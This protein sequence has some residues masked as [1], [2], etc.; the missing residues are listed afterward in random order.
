M[1]D[2]K[3]MKKAEIFSLLVRTGR[4][5]VMQKGAEFLTARK[6]S[7]A[8]GCSVGTIYNQFANMDNFIIVQNM[9]TLDELYEAMSQIVPSQNSYKNLV[10]YLDLYVDWVLH[11][12]NLWFLLFNFH[13]YRDGRNFPADY[14]RKFLKISQ[15]WQKDFE[16]S[17]RGLSIKE[18]RVL[19]QV[20]MLSMFSLSSFLSTQKT[21][22]I[23]RRNICKMFLNTYLA[24]VK[25]LCRA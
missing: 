9:L 6:L 18:R 20:L 23:S 3:D 1:K 14:L 11:H 7:E 19:R 13:L 24:G 22:K 5:L 10:R 16:A 12:T 17:L 2:I 4:E 21:S 25:S 8:S 15:I